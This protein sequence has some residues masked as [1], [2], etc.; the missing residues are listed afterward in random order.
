MFMFI[1][2][3]LSDFMTCSEHLNRVRVQ[4]TAL[5]HS[6]KIKFSIY[7]I[8][9]SDTHIHKVGMMLHWSDSV[10]CRKR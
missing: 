10:K 4:N 2:S 8:C 9:S 5:E 3:C 6:S 7:S 1:L